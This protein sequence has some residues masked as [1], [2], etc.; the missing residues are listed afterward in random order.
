MIED[1]PV[2]VQAGQ[3]AGMRTFAYAGGGMVARDQLEGP[4]TVVF[5]DM[6]LLPDCWRR[7]SVPSA[8]E[9]YL[10]ASTSAGRIS[11][12]SARS[13]SACAISAFAISPLM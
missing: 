9:R 3:A 6:R 1:S 5:D 7:R 8:A 11:G 2:G 12:G 13:S 4:A 10:E